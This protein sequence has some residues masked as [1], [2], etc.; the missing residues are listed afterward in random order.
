MRPLAPDTRLGPLE[1][2][3]LLGAGSMGTV[4]LARV[5]E[6]TSWA[7]AGRLVAA[8]VVRQDATI[9]PASGLRAEREAAA[10]R[11]VVHPGI[12]Q[13]L[14]L[15]RVSIDSIA[16]RVIVFEHVEGTDL[17]EMLAATGPLAEP[18]ARHVGASIAR[19]LA[20]LHAAG[21]VHRDVKPSNV[22][23]TDEHKV[24]DLG[25]A[26]LQGGMPL[27]D[28]GD[29]VGTAQYAA[30]E[31][32]TSAEV[33]PRADLHALG[34]TLYE[35]ST[36]RRPFEGGSWA[37]AM[38]R[39]LSEPARP[40]S[41]LNP[42]LSRFFDAIVL[43]LLEKDAAAR[44]ASAALVA[45]ALELGEVSA[46]W[47]DHGVAQGAPPA[48]HQLLSPSE[49][50]TI[51]RDVELATLGDRWRGACDGR[52]GSIVI[53][54][55][56][57]AGKSRLV[58]D[59]VRGLL[60]TASP[61]VLLTAGEP[62]PDPSSGPWDVI[63]AQFPGDLTQGLSEL[64]PDA[65]HLAEALGRHW[66]GRG[67]D[68]EA[69]TPATE[70]EGVAR[71]LKAWA[72]SQPVL[73]IVEDLHFASS[74]LR[75]QLPALAR[76]L[77]AAAVLIVA[78]T[79]EETNPDGDVSDTDLIRLAP[80]TLDESRR[81]VA[82]A[83]GASSMDAA[84][85]DALAERSDGNP[86]FALE[87]ARL[88]S[89]RKDGEG[90]EVSTSSVPRSVSSLL[91]RRLRLLPIEDR[92]ILDAACI[93][94]FEF[95]ARLL[96]RTLGRPELAVLQA[97]TRI[98]R[99]RALVRPAEARFRFEHHLLQE[100]LLAELPAALRASLHAATADA[101]EQE[102]PA[103]GTEGERSWMLAMH[104]L[105][106]T[107][108]ADGLAHWRE[109]V[110]WMNK[111]W[112]V[113]GILRTCELALPATGADDTRLR[114]EMLLQMGIAAGKRADGRRAMEFLEQALA[115]A[116]RSGDVALNLWVLQ[117]IGGRHSMSGDA[118]AAEA[119]MREALALAI[120]LGDDAKVL[121]ARYALAWVL[122]HAHRVE[123]TRSLLSEL[124]LDAERCGDLRLL[125]SALNGLGILARRDHDLASAAELF[126]RSHA[127]HVQIGDHARAAAPLGNLALVASQRGDLALAAD[128]ARQAS[129]IAARCG[130]VRQ[131]LSMVT[132]VG[133]VLVSLGRLP[134]ASAELSAMRATVEASGQRRLQMEHAATEA[135]ICLMEGRIDEAR[136]LCRE[137]QARD[138]MLTDTRVQ[139][140]IAVVLAE[141]A[142]A[143]EDGSLADSE[144]MRALQ[145]ALNSP[146]G[147]EVFQALRSRALIL[148]DSGREAEAR[149]IVES[150]NASHPK[151]H[152]AA[153]W[154]AL[155]ALLGLRS[156]DDVVLTAE[157]SVPARCTA[158]I[159]LARATRRE[160]LLSAARSELRQLVG[161]LSGAQR[162]R[163]M[164]RSPLGRR[165]AITAEL[166]KSSRDRRGE[167]P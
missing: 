115:E 24:A 83:L 100:V 44:P 101:L 77:S 49:S 81:L 95:D 87:L 11:A 109:C 15:E 79:R 121:A 28:T 35:V 1:V 45:E 61:R 99:A 124:V 60:G 13:A 89:S 22:L 92:E 23:I 150:A 96:A 155:E 91:R 133:G 40:P 145:L 55:E 103:A 86:M 118:P 31:Q 52:G 106:G 70:L 75:E 80:L 129:A 163:A 136:R 39:L 164:Q 110:E 82:Q 84:E 131:E 29:F 69:L 158:L 43:A 34:A 51:G 116:R 167:Q 6:A 105:Q 10:G 20:A 58:A 32:F 66:S 3:R 130:D 50:P 165:L 25:V 161:H 142:F 152:R 132:H 54:G 65:P 47:K 38:G 88:A 93:Q 14:A 135:E 144:S 160:E 141:A 126:H 107:R 72:G 147:T 71:V 104:R 120:A 12:V 56:A 59:F 41:S 17:A 74:T 21:I 76:A 36:G 111:R 140:G 157:Q 85:R 8:K 46:W 119:A 63:A 154:Q 57:G 148:V 97:L 64:L 137:G 98:H 90:D 125:A 102:P 114:A 94:G 62:T 9:H 30:P 146:Y 122:L 138:P 68:G 113:V 143:S 78:T 2:I 4:Y 151:N 27:T 117:N 48:L 73:W 159:L 108:P 134:E 67:A 149:S 128:L 153:D 112:D 26:H 19:A 18:L 139:A 123:E 37:Q 166:L 7:P 33:G 162:E 5:A 42:A 127:L 16:H 156:P 53:V